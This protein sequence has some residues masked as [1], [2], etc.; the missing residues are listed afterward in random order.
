MEY[1]YREALKLSNQ[2][3][4]PLYAAA[5]K[6]TSLYTPYLAPLNLTYTQYLVFLVLWEQDGIPVSEICRKLKLDNGTL[7]PLLKKMEKLGYLTRTRSTEDER[8]VLIKLTDLGRDMQKQ[9]ADIPMKV[10]S[11]VKLSPEKANL[12]YETLYEILEAPEQH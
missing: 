8:I 1:D 3:C 4:F 2:F 7:S 5:R 12:L 6:I 9:A 10:G 11:C